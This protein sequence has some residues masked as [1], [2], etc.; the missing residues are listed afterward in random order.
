MVI[1][2]VGIDLA[3]NAFAV[4]G[5]DDSGKPALVRPEVPHGKLM[6]LIAHLPPCLSGMEACS[7]AHKW[8]RALSS[9]SYPGPR[10]SINKPVTRNAVCLIQLPPHT[11]AHIQFR[12][13]VRSTQ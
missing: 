11:N 7:G 3:K 13:K 2:T 1:V 10:Q 8:N 5:V 6:E 4:H 9:G 12:A